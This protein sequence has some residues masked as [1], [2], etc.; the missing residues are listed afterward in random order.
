MGFF[1]GNNSH[2]PARVA[3]SGTSV[4]I[5]EYDDLDFGK[6]SKL[7]LRGASIKTE[8]DEGLEP[9]TSSSRNEYLQGL[10]GGQYHTLQQY[11]YPLVKIFNNIWIR[12]NYKHEVYVMPHREVTVKLDGGDVTFKDEV[13]YR[14]SLA[15]EACPSGWRL[16]SY[17]DYQNMVD[18]LADL[19]TSDVPWL[20]QFKGGG[21]YEKESF[22][23]NAGADTS[24]F[25][26]RYVKK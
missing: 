26:V 9:K 11:D 20:A 7:Y 17:D 1:L 2:K 22:N 13:F 24:Y 12:E 8:L 16:P 23:N 3:W 15:E 19:L 25:S 6:V 5:E 21:Q 4:S 18:K 10:K 14:V